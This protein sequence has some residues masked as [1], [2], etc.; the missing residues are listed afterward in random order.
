MTPDL[1]PKGGQTTEPYPS[2]E[3]GTGG[4]LYQPCTGLDALTQQVTTCL[5]NQLCTPDLMHSSR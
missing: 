3:L 4:D 2:A 5:T 1:I